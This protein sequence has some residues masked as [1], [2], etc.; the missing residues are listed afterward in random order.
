[1]KVPLDAAIAAA[2]A[3][4]LATPSEGELVAF[5]TDTR[6][7]APGDAFVALRGERFDGHDYVRQALA[8]GATLLV[9]DDPSVV[10]SGV[11]ALVVRDTTHAYLAFAAVARARSAARIV[12]VP[13][14]AGKTTT[15]NFL[16]QILR[17]V[18][19]GLV[20]T[21][22]G[23]ENN[24]IGVAKLLLALPEDAAFVVIEMGARHFGEI[25]PLARAA[26][27]ELAIVTNIG[28]AH[29]EIF[30]S[31][32]RLEQ[33][34]WGI[35][36]TG[37]R[38]ILGA[39]DA[40]S[41]R[42]ASRP[43]DGVATTWFAL[44]E[45]PET[46]AGDAGAVLFG[47]ERL[48]HKTRFGAR[49]FPTDVRVPGDHNRL[50]A[51]AAAAAALELGFDGA[52]VAAA[53]GSLALPPG[54]Y[55]RIALGDMALLYDAYNASMGGTLATLASFAREPAERRIA[56]LGS[57]AELGPDAAAMHARVGAAAAGSVDLLLVGGE[58]AD[59]LARGARGAG[60]DASRIVPFGDNASAVSWLRHN[61]RA[62]DLVLLKASRRYKLEEIVEGLRSV[63]AG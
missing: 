30:G 22:P 33:T 15:K 7:L 48:V 6:T 23:N 16:D 52:A 18:Q 26:R 2:G 8:A 44:D 57:M 10:P 19:Q 11:A 32:E 47:R 37:A 9:V 29:L 12:A 27:P 63:H 53:L 49:E 55:E 41:R 24:E 20:V 58:H 13:G 54:R 40:R 59:D 34:K 38:R 62:G 31:Q 45:L 50:N 35:F 3:R 21:T 14:S 60:F 5:S 1:M 25:V 28:D 56:V 4:A 51:A 61:V 43:S 36:A 39:S 42:L 17:R 46:P